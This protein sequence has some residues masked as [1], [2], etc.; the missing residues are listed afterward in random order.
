MK[1]YS[2]KGITDLGIYYVLKKYGNLQKSLKTKV[3]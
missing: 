1:N 3:Q 2:G